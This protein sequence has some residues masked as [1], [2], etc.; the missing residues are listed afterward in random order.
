MFFQVMACNKNTEI[1]HIISIYMF[2]NTSQII[3]SSMGLFLLT[4]IWSSPMLRIR[5]QIFDL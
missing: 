5:Q 2:F 4:A 3:W 1:T